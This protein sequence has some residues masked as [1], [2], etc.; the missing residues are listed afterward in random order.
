VNSWVTKQ[1]Q[2]RNQK[3]QQFWFTQLKIKLKYAKQVIQ[4]TQNQTLQK[5]HFFA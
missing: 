1:N 4:P 3:T 5:M 2:T